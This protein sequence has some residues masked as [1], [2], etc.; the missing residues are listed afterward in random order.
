MAKGDFIDISM[1]GEPELQKKLNSIANNLGQKALKK[2]FRDGAKIIKETAKSIVPS[3][4]GKLR[5]YLTVRAIK[6]GRARYIGRGLKVKD[7]KVG[8]QTPK[9]I[10]LGIDQDTKWYYPAHLEL[11]HRTKSGGWQPAVPFLRNALKTTD[12]RVLS[13]VRANLRRYIQTA[14]TT[15]RV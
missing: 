10:K 3:K 12:Q 9:K 2:A 6:S 8:V 14:S 4:T 13:I 1:L 15:G 5:R 11:G 7:I